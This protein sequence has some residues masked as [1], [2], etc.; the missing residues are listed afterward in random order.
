MENK[1]Q[2]QKRRFPENFR[3]IVIARMKEKDEII[4]AIKEGRIADMVREGKISGKWTY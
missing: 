2:K 4:Q 1:D 3:Q